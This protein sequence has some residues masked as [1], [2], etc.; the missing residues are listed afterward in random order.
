MQHNKNDSH[1]VDELAGFSEAEKKALQAA[2]DAKTPTHRD[3]DD[4]MARAYAKSGIDP[5][6]AAQMR[7]SKSIVGKVQGPFIA[8]GGVALALVG[9]W[10]VWN[11][12]NYSRLSIGGIAMIGFGIAAIIG[13][14][15]GTLRI[16]DIE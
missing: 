10:R 15:A 9:C 12:W 4:L 2:R 11:A 3:P 8:F 5:L 13:G 7:D 6:K 1:S 16:D 14:I